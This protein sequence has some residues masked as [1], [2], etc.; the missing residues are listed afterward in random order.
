MDEVTDEVLIHRV[1]KTDDRRAFAMLV[2][3]HQSELRGSL[4]RI[5]QGDHARADDVAQEAFIKAY[6][7]LRGFNGKSSFRTWLYKIALNSY[8]NEQRKQQRESSRMQEYA[9]HQQA[10]PDTTASESLLV[11]RDVRASLDTL[12][13]PQ[14]L[15]VDLNLQRGFSHQEI[16]EITGIP[17]GTVKSHLSRAR[18]LLQGL[19]LDFKEV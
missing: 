17:L 19:L 6:R 3:R 12:S 14:Q 10:P 7:Y 9:I 18:T 13:S 15:V 4:R 1:V 16:V 2:Q 11:Q 8:I 5:S